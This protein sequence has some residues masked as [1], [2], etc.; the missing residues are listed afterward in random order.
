MKL[1][2]IDD[3]LL[4][5]KGLQTIIPWEQFGFTEIF[6]ATDGT[7]GL[8]LIRDE[9]PELVLMDI[10]MQEIDGLQVTA[11]AHAEDF[12]GRIIIIS[13]YSDFSYAQTAIHQDVT[14]YLLKPVDPEDLTKAIEK[15]LG[16]LEKENFFS[17][18]SRQP[19]RNTKTAILTDLVSGRLLY[20]IELNNT[21]H[22]GLQTN[23]LCFIACISLSDSPNVSDDSAALTDILKSNCE[24]LLLIDGIFYLLLT[25]QAEHRL[26]RQNIKKYVTECRET[27]F[28]FILGRSFDDVQQLTNQYH[29]L[30]TISRDFFYYVNSSHYYEITG[31][32]TLPCSEHFDLLQCTQDMLNAILTSN[33][34]ELTA[35]LEQLHQYLIFRHPIR[36]TIGFILGN[37]YWQITSKLLFHYPQLEVELLNKEEFINQLCEK[38]FLYEYIKL[39]ELQFQH[40]ITLLIQYHNSIPCENICRYV[41]ENFGSPLRLQTIAKEFGY[42][43]T[44]LGRLFKKEKNMSFTTYVDQ[45]RIK[46]AKMLLDKNVSVSQTAQNTG[47]NDIDYFT[48]KFKK[49]VGCSPSEYKKRG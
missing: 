47:F 35:L 33:R 22:L 24:N 12:H 45:V 15:A 16:E 23:Y 27:S 42:N 3:E 5:R 2:I 18:Y 37:C 40:C 4:I 31:T 26:C 32:E 38:T 8:Q 46:H 41:E 1:L 39:L 43:Y 20:D 44:Y 7:E 28:L 29:T 36:D 25:S 11:R 48:K 10:R 9:N 21:Y 17:L 19:M 6:E 34:S 49:Y 13:G 30:R 14:A